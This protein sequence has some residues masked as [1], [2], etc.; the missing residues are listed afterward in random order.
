MSTFVTTHFV[1]Q[2]STLV[3]MLLQQKGSKLRGTVSAGSY[4]GNAA[5]AVEQVGLVT[6]Q[7][8]TTRHADTPIS[9][10]PADARWVFPK[11]YDI[12]DLIDDQ[13]KLRMIIDP[14]SSYAMAQA[15]ALGRAMD[16]E[17]ISAFFGT[18]LT[19]AS[20]STSTTFPTSTST[21]VVGVST[22]GTTS[23][24]NVEKLRAAKEL[25]MTNEVDVDNED[26]YCVVTAKQYR[27]LLNEIQAVSMDFTDK[28]VLVNGKITE[29]MGFKFV[30]CQRLTTGTD[31]AAGTSRQ[32]PVYAKSGMHLGIWNDINSSVDKR[33]DKSNS[34]QVY[35]KMTV[36]A[37]RVEEGKVVKIWCRE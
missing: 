22:G 20:G 32:I 7:L 6:A 25:L 3:Q 27:N 14:Q 13:D 36:G 11:D 15:M 31:D 29:F 26:L 30:P 2:Y 9:S 21:N 1:Q 16:D 37:T 12:A 17:I 5:K 35:S 34:T 28:P 24:L 23:G 19:G 4:T 10:T 18:S 8:R 33:A